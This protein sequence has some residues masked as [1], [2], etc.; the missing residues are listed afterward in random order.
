MVGEVEF[1]PAT[2]QEAR[3]AVDWYSRRSR[4]AAV[5]LVLEFDVALA[6]IAEAPE[7]WPRAGAGCRRYVLHRFPFLVIYREHPSRLAP[8]RMREGD[9]VTGQEESTPRA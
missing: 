4:L 9:P 8:S 2:L 5:A 3:A 1:H 7:R 6:A